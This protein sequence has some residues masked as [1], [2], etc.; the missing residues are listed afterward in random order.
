MD[1]ELQLLLDAVQEAGDSI[2]DLQKTGFSISKK[3]ED[4]IVTKADLLADE[5]IKTRLLNAF[6]QDGWLSEESVDDVHRLAC[7]RVWVVD[8]ID[9][10]REFA[11][12]VPE[13]A[14]SVALVQ[15]GQPILSAVFNPATNEFFH[16]IK[17][18]GAWLGK[19]KI[20]CNIP[21]QDFLL[22]ASRSEYR[23]GEWGKYE[24]D[25]R[26]KQVGSIAYKLGLIAA[27]EGDA[28]FS[29]GPK[30]E[31]DIAAGVLLV[32]EAG[33]VVTDK[34]RNPFLFNRKEVKVNGIV[35]SAKNIN[36]EI[37]AMIK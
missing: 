20:Q 5:I 34:E 15:E 24:R 7:K 37:F 33:G 2:L 4:D 6:P 29:L 31:W 25:H 9:G 12:G 21:S 16:A 27:G 32:T 22:L 26:V 36:D 3:G 14:I 1:K 28:T 30:N 19:R 17:G 18:Q 23:R 35:A 10:T 11:S 8:P 13:Y